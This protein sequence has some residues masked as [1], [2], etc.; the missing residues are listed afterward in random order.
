MKRKGYLN[1]E[2]AFRSIWQN[3]GRDGIWHG[4]ATSLAE[5]FDASENDAESVLEELR[6]R[7][8]IERLSAGTYLLS[9]W[10]QRDDRGTP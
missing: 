6:E 3:S 5:K 9:K 4:D 10:R 7:R 8:L 2:E 1:W